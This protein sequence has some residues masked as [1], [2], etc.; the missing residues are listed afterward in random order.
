[1]VDDSWL[2]V[3]DRVFKM[4]K[5]SAKVESHSLKTILAPFSIVSSRRPLNLNL[6]IS[7]WDSIRTTMG[8]VEGLSRCLETSRGE[9]RAE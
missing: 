7:S 3:L 2:Y 8:S 4:R 6:L 9:P 5:S 1:M